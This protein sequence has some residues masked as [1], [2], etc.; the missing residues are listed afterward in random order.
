[1]RRCE[2]S[3]ISTYQPTVMW[4]KYRSGLLELGAA[5]STVLICTLMSSDTLLEF[6]VLMCAHMSSDT[7]LEFNP[8]A[9]CGSVRD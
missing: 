6:T 4:C 8:V 5:T 2:R 7:L 1:M 3:C 9:L